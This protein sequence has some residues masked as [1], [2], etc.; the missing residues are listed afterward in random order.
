MEGV[1]GNAA[2][3]L[4]GNVRA[5]EETSVISVGTLV[6]SNV[7][8][9]V[10]YVSRVRIDVDLQFAVD[11]TSEQ[12]AGVVNVQV[13]VQSRGVVQ[14]TCHGQGRSNVSRADDQVA[15]SATS[16]LSD[17]VAVALDLEQQ[18]LELLNAPA[19]VGVNVEV[20]S[21][22]GSNVVLSAR[23]SG[24]IDG[25]NNFAVDFSKDLAGQ[26]VSE[27]CFGVKTVDGA[28]VLSKFQTVLALQSATACFDDSLLDAEGPSGGKRY[29]RIRQQ[30]PVRQWR[31][32]SRPL[33]EPS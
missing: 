5:V 17:G 16:L 8:L 10:G 12:V 2:D 15:L 30:I 33:V 25:A 4:Q 7:V 1:S 23:N 13:S 14:N 6:T 22:G 28:E 18:T 20:E 9:G 11:G 29:Q 24:L 31:D 3:H 26:D 21:T 32:P 27:F 19:T